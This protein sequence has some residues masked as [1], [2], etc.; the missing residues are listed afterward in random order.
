MTTPTRDESTSLRNQLLI[1]MPQLDDPNFTRSVIL[2]CRHDA[3]GAMGITVNRV[4]HHRMGEIFEQLSL[5]ISSLVWSNNP[6]LCGGPVSPELGLVLHTPTPGQQWESS[7]AISQQ[8]SVTSSQDI[9]RA[10]A[11]GQGPKR[12]C[13][14]LGYAGWTAG[15]LEAE[16]QQNAWLSVPAD[17]NIIFGLDIDAKWQQA[18]MLLGIDAANISTQVGHA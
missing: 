13:I 6:V 10:L 2:L 9:L 4:T 18:A 16:L 11:Q 12:A 14:S 1:S 17:E 8:L 7:I 5:P 15:Q 3:D